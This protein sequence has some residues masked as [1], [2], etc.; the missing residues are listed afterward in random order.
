MNLF[1]KSK[2]QKLSFISIEHLI[3]ETTKNTLPTILDTLKRSGGVFEEI[4]A[5]INV[6]AINYELARF[7]LY[8]G[9]EK[10]DVDEVLSD[11][12]S[13]L[14]YIL[15]IDTE[16]RNSYDEYINRVIKVSN[17]IF[18]VKRLGGPAEK[19]VYRL[20]LE[21]LKIRE[22]NISKDIIPEFVFYANSW[23]NNMKNINETYEIDT[24]EEGR[25]SDTIDF[26]F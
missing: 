18:N 1:S 17:E 20:L 15:K 22:D 2:K 10:K 26:R 8:K 3:E 23:V 21:Q 14:P 16:K 12:Y 25:K 7:A 4:D 11:L 13:E 5:K 6:M 9:N 24:T 19:F